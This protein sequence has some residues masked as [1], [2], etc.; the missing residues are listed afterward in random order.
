MNDRSVPFHSA[1]FSSVDPFVD[2]R[3][4]NVNYLPKEGKGVIL[5]PTNPVSSRR[6]SQGLH[7]PAGHQHPA[8]HAQQHPLLS[9]PLHLPAPRVSLFIMNA[10]YQTFLSTKRMRLHETGQTIDL[11]RYRIP[12]LEE[13]QH[14][15]DRVIDQL[16]GHR[17]EQ[18]LPT[19]PPDSPSPSSS[20]AA[21]SAPAPTPR[22]L[23]HC[24]QRK[25]S[26]IPHQRQRATPQTSRSLSAPRPDSRP[27][28]NDRTPRQ[29]RL[30]QVPS[31][32]PEGPP[33]PRRRRRAHEQGEFLRR[34][35]HHLA[36]AKHFEVDKASSRHTHEVLCDERTDG[37]EGLWRVMTGIA[38]SMFYNSIS[39]METRRSMLSSRV[40]SRRLRSVCCGLPEGTPRRTRPI[41]ENVTDCRFIKSR[42]KSS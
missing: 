12:F 30:H 10:A 38:A 19:P 41:E 36:L 11:D 13:T 25:T 31:A 35:S 21:S 37:H 6:R 9:P 14:V 22:I 4:I 16:A 2:V 15:E 23:Q 28:R 33:H 24:P 7:H 1:A 20:T 17:P 18:Y 32:H 26:D 27:V 42:L 5:D 40:R 8:R 39:R 34:Q 29:T 3:K